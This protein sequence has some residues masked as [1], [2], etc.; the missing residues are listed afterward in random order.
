MGFELVSA[1]QASDITYSVDRIVGGGS[2]TGTITTDGTTGVL[3][4]SNIVGFD[5]TLNGIGLSS[6]LAS[7]TDGVYTG[8]T[9]LTAT[10]S[11]IFF[12]F[13]SYRSYLDFQAVYG[14]GADYYT[15]AAAGVDGAYQGESVNPG[16]YTDSH[17]INV[18]QSGNQII[19]TAGSAVP[20]PTS[21][22]M[23]STG[24]LLALAYACC[25]RVRTN[26]TSASMPI[27]ARREPSQRTRPPR[28]CEIV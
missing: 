2:V 8:G 10:P 3:S 28:S 4:A 1:C 9:G 23:T 15:D 24:V 16:F 19:A 14:N 18:P 17:F 12:D 22:V 27:P 26:I 11:D 6:T 5:L 25:R 20:E 21:L 13:G 7:P